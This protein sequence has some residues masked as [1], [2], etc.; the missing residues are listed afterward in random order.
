M[1][2]N[3]RYRKVRDRASYAFALVSVAA[4]LQVVDG[5]VREVRIALGG[6]GAKPWRADAAERLLIGAPAS[7]AS[8]RRAADAELAHAIGRSGNQFKVELACRTIVATLHQLR[9]TGGAA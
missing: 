2:G 1:A 7:D 8:F 5:L 9:D 3:S 4:A 6:V